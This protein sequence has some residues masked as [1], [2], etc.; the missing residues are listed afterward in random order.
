MLTE[1]AMLQVF[2]GVRETAFELHQAAREDR[3]RVRHSNSSSDSPSA[4]P[5]WWGFRGLLRQMTPTAIRP[6]VIG[7][8]ATIQV[9]AGMKNQLRPEDHQEELDKWRQ[10][11]DARSSQRRRR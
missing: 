5:T 3:A 2:E 11:Q 7:S 10:R 6:I 9:L 8:Q 1:F 4:A